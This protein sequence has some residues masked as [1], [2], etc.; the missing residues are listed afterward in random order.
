MIGKDFPRVGCDL[1]ENTTGEGGLQKGGG[2]T[3]QQYK[4]GKLWREV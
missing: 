4:L 1:I 2:G 3:T